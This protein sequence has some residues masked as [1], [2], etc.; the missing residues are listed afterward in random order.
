MLEPIL[1]HNLYRNIIWL[2]DTNYR[3]DMDNAEVRAH[4][5][6]DYLDPLIAADQVSGLP[7]IATAANSHLA[8]ACHGYRCCIYWL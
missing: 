3:I 7:Q 5:E 1:M 4:A 2:A 8:S 6:A